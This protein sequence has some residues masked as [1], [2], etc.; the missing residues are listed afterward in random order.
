VCAIAKNETPYLE[1]WINFHRAVGVE[2]FYIY[3]NESTI[4]VSETLQKY[5]EAG[6]ITVINFPGLGK[7]MPAYTDCLNRF[8]HSSKWIA[9]IDCD[10]FIVTKTYDSVPEV[11]ARYEIYGGLA[12]NWII[13]GSNGHMTKPGGLLIE[14]YTMGSPK[15]YV[16]NRHVKAIVQPEFTICAGTNPHHFKHRQGHFSVS[17]SGYR[18]SQAWADNTTNIIQINHYFTKSRE[19]FLIKCARGRADV[20]DR[21]IPGR[22]IGEFDSF[23]NHCTVKDECALR[24]VEKTKSLYL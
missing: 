9:F 4:P 22:H 23:N 15:D 2:H 7:Q 19:E 3:D 6:L 14:N 5:L 17:E 1:E 11:L 10:E 21:N 16:E 12:V 13:F 18:V 8:G 20:A 24:F